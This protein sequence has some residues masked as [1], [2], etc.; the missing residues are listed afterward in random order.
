MGGLLS[1]ASI[2]TDMTNHQRGA[3]STY[4]VDSVDCGSC[5]FQKEKKSSKWGKSYNFPLL[6]LCLL[7]LFKKDLAICRVR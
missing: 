7:L 6:L 3:A 4:L 2:S 1:A 5:I